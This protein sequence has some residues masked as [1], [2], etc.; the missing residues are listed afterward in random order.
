V[1]QG[2]ETIS[3]RHIPA[4]DGIRGIAI[5]LV[6]L[7]HL[8]FAERTGFPFVDFFYRV[9][10]AGWVGVDLFF[11]LSGFLITGIL[12][13]ARAE[14]FGAA[15]YFRNFYARRT[16][17]IFPLYYTIL[18][19][20][21]VLTLTLG[22]GDND[23]EGFRHSQFWLWSFTAN[24]P[25]AWSNHFVLFK[26]WHL[27]FSPFWSL[28]VEEQ[29][30]FFW[31]LMVWLCPPKRLLT[32][33]IS[34]AV[35]STIARIIYVQLTSHEITAYVLTPLRLDGLLIGAACAVIVRSSSLFSS[36][37]R[38]LPG[39]IVAWFALIAIIFIF[40][41]W[42]QA[43][44]FV[45]GIGFTILDL[46]FAAIILSCVSGRGSVT[47]IARLGWLRMLGKYSYGL[48]VLHLMVLAPM[49]NTTHGLYGRLVHHNVW[50]ELAAKPL[51]AL[52][53]VAAAAF[54]WHFF[55]SPFLK[56]KRH[57]TYP[58]VQRAPVIEGAPL[59]TQSVLPTHG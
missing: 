37:S 13:E 58:V 3:Q 1:Y 22:R 24:L 2:P 7:C 50:T 20:A 28:A 16:L 46:G 36:L 8:F 23:P 14:H 5:A 49:L 17:R 10:S 18:I 12:I 41:S 40:T 35:T 48:Y 39:I 57:F 27:T 55:E 43:N 19:L 6:L 51:A 29:F 59:S 52:A 33:T 11:V 38:A 47:Q 34:M 30:Y 53:A 42:Q 31:P 56:F 25:M 26:A 9:A 21:L 15:A 32:V 45:S 44:R 4:L 54:S